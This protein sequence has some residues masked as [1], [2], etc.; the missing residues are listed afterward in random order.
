MFHLKKCHRKKQ[1][2]KC[3][4]PERKRGKVLQ[5]YIEW[6][7]KET[8]QQGLKGSEEQARLSCSK[9]WPSR[10]GDEESGLTFLNGN[11]CTTPVGDAEWGKE[12][13]WWGQGGI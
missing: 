2:E 1:S 3:R 9:R 8:F 5:F 11:K 10:Q 12:G 6:S 13:W 7:E 4:G